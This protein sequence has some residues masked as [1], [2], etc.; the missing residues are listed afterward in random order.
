MSADRDTTA[1]RRWLSPPRRRIAVVLVLALILGVGLTAMLWRG[2]AWTA[3]ELAGTGLVVELPVPPQGSHAGTAEAPVPLF[4]AHCADLAVLASGGPV[5]AGPR[6]DAAFLAR[7]ALAQVQ[8][9]PGFSDLDYQ[10]G[11]G[12]I[13]GAPCLLVGGTFRRDGVACRLS[14]AFFVNSETH[15]HL[16]CFWQTAEGARLARRVLDSVRPASS[17]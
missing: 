8:L 11:E 17:R 6:P 15:G 3:Y 9:S 10:L 13:Q 4:Q 2:P 7:Q 1:A 12:R 16:L 14:G 5:P